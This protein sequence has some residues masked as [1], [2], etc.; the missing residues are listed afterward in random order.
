MFNKKLEDRVAYLEGENKYIRG[1]IFKL[2]NPNGIISSEYGYNYQRMCY[3][4]YYDAEF[5]SE[6]RKVNICN[7]MP[8][9]V[10]LYFEGSNVILK[11]IFYIELKEH[12]EYFI[13]NKAPKTCSKMSNKLFD[14]KLEWIPINTKLDDKQLPTH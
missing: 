10:F 14:N 11:T 8:V 9:K 5:D 12:T 6:I 7:F 2:K 1:E 13:L 3:T 4:Y